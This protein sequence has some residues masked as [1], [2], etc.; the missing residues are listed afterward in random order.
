[1]TR[2][3]LPKALKDYMQNSM[4]PSRIQ[5]SIIP[6]PPTSV[7]VDH[8]FDDARNLLIK[9]INDVFDEF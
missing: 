3:P 8:L 5:R 4:E 6:P 9:E 7:N 1:M 2:D